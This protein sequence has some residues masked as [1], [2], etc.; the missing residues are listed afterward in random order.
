MMPNTPPDAQSDRVGAT[1]ADAFTRPVIVTGAAGF[2]GSHVVE[3]L[4][5]RGA[6]VVGVDNFDPF[7][8]RRIK[9]RNLAEVSESARRVG[10]A[11][12][13]MVEWREGDVAR[14]A[15]MWASQRGPGVAFIER[16]ITDAKGIRELFD[17]VRPG[18]VIHLAAKAGVRPS[19][20]DP[21]G[22]M[23]ANVMGTSVILDAAARAR[24]E[25]KR[26]G[27]SGVCARMVVASS[28]S[29]YGNCNVPAGVGFSEELDVNE[30]ISPYAASKRA[31]ELLAFTHH[32]L[33]G[34]PT[35][36]LRFF[37]VYGPRQRPDLAISMF[38]K[39]VSKG[40]P[41]R[42]FGDGTTSRDYTYVDDIVAGVIASAERIGTE[43]AYRVWNLGGNKSTTLADMIAT[44][45]RVVGR[46][47]IV[48]KAAMQPGDVERT[49]ADLTRSGRE[50]AFAPKVRFEEGVARQW[51]WMA[52]AGDPPAPPAP[53]TAARG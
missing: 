45:G 38:L 48:Q 17:S 1:G 10:S 7:Y 28:S 41:I 46:E 37:T 49:A 47:P 2:I 30:P 35:A 40:E 36:C 31:C 52:K 53:T 32:L 43:H 18:V 9:A 3:A 14:G 12:G 50:I 26:E 4:L 15:R 11:G 13:A 20:A 16:D 44:I 27:E 25:A 34:M 24:D 22:Y 33:T 6:R 5:A 23:H 21:A 19:I 51:A 8:D 39:S 42:M 29:V